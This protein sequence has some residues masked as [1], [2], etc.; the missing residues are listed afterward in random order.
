MYCMA[1]DLSQI[2]CPRI[3]KRLYQIIG[4][5][6]KYCNPRHVEN[7]LQWALNIEFDHKKQGGVHG[8]LFP[9]PTKKGI[10]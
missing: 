6:E 5:I 1:F 4:L 3:L 2:L 9:P 8:G 10:F 7:S